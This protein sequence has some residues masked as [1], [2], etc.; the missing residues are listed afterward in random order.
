M[1]KLLLVGKLHDIGKIGIPEHILL[2]T[3]RLA[4]DEYEIMKTHSEKGYR[5][6]LLLPELSHIS[7][8]ILT[9]H[10]RWDG[11][12]YPLGL[13][14]EEIPLIARI[15]SVVDAFDSMTHDRVYSKAVS[16]TDA[17]C[18]LKNCAGEQFD[19]SIVEAFCNILEKI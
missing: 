5:L 13:K 18:E 10:E 9:H 15:V 3:D 16:K 6:A 12:G 19:P 17:I 8:A 4:D 11:K 7:R 1:D 14:E 2:K